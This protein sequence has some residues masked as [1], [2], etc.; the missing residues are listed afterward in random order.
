MEGGHEGDISR[1]FPQRMQESGH[2]IEV[3]E[4]PDAYFSAGALARLKP[5]CE[6]IVLDH[7][8]RPCLT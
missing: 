2:K 5:V 8:R 6:A 4:I 1:Q 7:L 3:L